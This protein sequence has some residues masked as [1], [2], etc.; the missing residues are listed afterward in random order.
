MNQIKKRD[1]AESVVA[2]LIISTI[3]ALIVA[4]NLNSFVQA[5]DLFPGGFTG[6]TRLIMRCA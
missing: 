3:S 2:R 5:G 4:V 1:L 6:L